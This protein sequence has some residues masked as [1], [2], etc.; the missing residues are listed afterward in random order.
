[1]KSMKLNF[2]FFAMLK[3]EKKSRQNFYFKFD[4][5]FF[6]FA[7]HFISINDTD[8]KIQFRFQIWKKNNE[9]PDEGNLLPPSTSIKIVEEIG[10]KWNVH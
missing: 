7:L 6:I 5:F 3:K 10:S 2:V 9:G 8:S 4:Y 1:M